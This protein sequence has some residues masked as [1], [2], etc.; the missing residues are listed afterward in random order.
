LKSEISELNKFGMEIDE[1]NKLYNSKKEIM[2]TWLKIQNE[3]YEKYDDYMESKNKVKNYNN[4]KINNNLNIDIK[5]NLND[6]KFSVN[7]AVKKGSNKIYEDIIF[8]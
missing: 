1:L 6:K 8:S 3:R 5:N 2:R 7:F 4:K